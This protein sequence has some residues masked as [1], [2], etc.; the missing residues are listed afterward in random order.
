MQL[1]HKPY[2]CANVALDSSCSAQIWFMSA[3]AAVP[4]QVCAQY[5]ITAIAFLAEFGQSM[6]LLPNVAGHN[7]SEVGPAITACQSYGA[8]IL[9]SM[10]GQGGMQPLRFRTLCA[11]I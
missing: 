7:I 6:P 11:F 2:V 4:F 1:F 10:G 8:K 9:L 5:N 3:S